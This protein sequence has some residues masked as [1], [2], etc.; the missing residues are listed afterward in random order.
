MGTGVTPEAVEGL[1]ASDP[2]IDRT[3]IRGKDLPFSMR[4]SPAPQCESKGMARGIRERDAQR[5]RYRAPGE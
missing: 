5:K 2:R 4:E 3:P 1:T